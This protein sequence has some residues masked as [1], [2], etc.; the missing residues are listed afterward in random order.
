[1]AIRSILGLLI[2]GTLGIILAIAGAG[3]WALA[4]QVLA[5]RIAEFVIA[6][7]AAPVRM[8]FRWSHVHFRELS[9]V[10]INVFTGLIM[11]F[12]GGQVPRL[13]I[14]FMLGPTELGLFTLA[15]RF[16]EMIVQTTVLPPTGVGRIELRASKPGSP[17]FERTF[18]KMTQNV[19]LLSFPIFLGAAALAPDVFQLWLNERWLA[20]IVPMQFMLLSGIPLV[21]FYCIDQ[22][23]FAANQSRLYVRTSVA[24]TLTISATVLCAAPFGLPLTCLALAIRPWVLLPIFLVLL[25]RTCRLPIFR[26]LLSPVYSLIGAVLMGALLTLPALHPAWLSELPNFVLLVSVGII[27][28]FI[29]L[30][31]FLR[32]QFKTLV[33]GIF[34]YRS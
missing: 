23:F 34:T 10:G 4:I 12:A 7:I 22:A 31:L 15:T 17:E 16:L 6:W 32:D 14:G 33:K 5:Q 19:T 1:L 21:L 28:Y 13:I 3:V 11:S 2:G 24:Q 20:G 8:G 25:R 26:I 29:F 30:T 9:P 18:T 27:L